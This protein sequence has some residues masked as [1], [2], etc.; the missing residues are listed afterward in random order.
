VLAVIGGTGL[1]QMEG[2]RSAG[3]ERVETPYGM[4]SGPVITGTLGGIPIVFLARHGTAHQVPAHE[5]NYRANV[6]A[7][8]EAGATRVLA[9]CSVGGIAEECV[10]GAL[11]VP[12]QLID[13]TWG[14]EHTFAGQE[15]APM[16]TDFTHP[17]TNGWRKQVMSSL[18]KLGIPFIN[19][20]TYAAMQGPRFETAAEIK[21]LARDGCTI[22]GMTAMPEAFLAREMN[23]DYAAICPVGNPAAGLSHEPVTE[24]QVATNAAPVIDRIEELVPALSLKA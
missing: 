5:V 14:R 12:D 8:A 3:G 17:F 18:G 21:R 13:Y 22:V 4:T 9:V 2:L 15:A 7:L 10:P 6:R 11:V 19:G 23:L 20:G 24:T 16:H 1:Y